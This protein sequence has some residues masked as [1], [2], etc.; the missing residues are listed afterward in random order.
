MSLLCLACLFLTL[1]APPAL[2]APTASRTWTI[3]AALEVQLNR[4]GAG[5]CIWVVPND[6]ASVPATVVLLRKRDSAW[7]IARPPFPAVIGRNGMAPEGEK[8][9]GDGRTPSGI[10]P[11]GFAFGYAPTLDIRWRYRPSSPDDVWIDDPEAPDYNTLTRKS[12]TQAKSFEYMKRSDDLYKLGLV[13]E[14]NTAPVVASLG[15][16]IFMHLWKDQT[17]GTAGCVAMAE[18]S[19][20]TLLAWLNPDFRVFV[21]IFPNEEPD[22]SDAP[23]LKP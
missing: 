18:P 12:H 5:Q 21:A 14:Y 22:A 11:L 8:R 1:S 7:E 15:S 13:V 3:P 17:T 20:L 16:A 6:P 19:M 4:L 23:R 9:E 2:A 10:F